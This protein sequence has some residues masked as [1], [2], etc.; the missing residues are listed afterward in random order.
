MLLAVPP[1]RSSAYTSCS[2]GER[3]NW[4]ESF[5]ILTW[6][7][8]SYVG[9]A[10]ELVRTASAVQEFAASWCG[11]PPRLAARTALYTM[12]TS[13]RYT[14]TATTMKPRT[15][16]SPPGMRA[17]RYP[18]AKPAMSSSLATRRTKTVT[19]QTSD[20]VSLHAVIQQYIDMVDV[21]VFAPYSRVPSQPPEPPFKIGRS[22][23]T[24][25]ESGKITSVII[26][27]LSTRL[28]R[29]TKPISRPAQM[30]MPH[31]GADDAVAKNVSPEKYEY[32]FSR[33][34]AASK[35]T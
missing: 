12:T 35:K 11:L 26:S 1:C 32:M 3:L 6:V 22:I 29:M 23:R 13:S 15:A 14:Q 8:S 25:M 9:P 24:P 7:V 16:G 18:A 31:M 17:K 5:A 21:N 34:I 30:S 10:W 4:L 19:R 27:G 20:L 33:P 2:R 28:R